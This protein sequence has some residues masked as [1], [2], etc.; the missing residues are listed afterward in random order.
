MIVH[1]TFVTVPV[2]DMKRAS[3]FY[4]AAFGAKSLFALP[5]FS[6]FQIAGVRVG[7]GLAEGHAPTD[8]HLHFAVADL[9]AA[10]AD[11]ER[12]GGR[13]TIARLEVAPGVF[14]AHCLDSEGNELVLA[15]R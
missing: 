3:A 14:H 8:T 6:S 12:A 15:L 7:L 10:C 11:V 5:F 9:A 1:E 4:V 13:V 2:A